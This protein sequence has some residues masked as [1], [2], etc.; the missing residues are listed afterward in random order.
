MAQC[1]GGQMQSSPQPLA[2]KAFFSPS[3]LVA[4]GDAARLRGR[5]NLADL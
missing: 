1:M 3:L 5:L 2:L 4:H